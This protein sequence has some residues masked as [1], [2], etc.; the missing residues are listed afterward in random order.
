M[1]YLAPALLWLLVIFLGIGT[2]AGLY[3]SRVVVPIW[4]ETP[5][6][7]WVQTGTAFW[8]FVSTGPL[9]LIVLVSL[10]AVWRFDGPARSWWRAAIG[11]ATVERIATFTYFIPTMVWLQQQ[12]GMSA[13]VGSTLATWSALNHGRHVL[14]IAAWLLSLKALSLISAGRAELR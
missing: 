1:R 2:G 14:A 11:I 8:A 3:E 6:E 4:A 10:A 5:P 9:T 12:T 7:T 13:E